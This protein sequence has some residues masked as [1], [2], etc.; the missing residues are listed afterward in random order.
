MA[1]R[2]RIELAPTGYASLQGLR[3]RKLRHEV[4]K[5]ID[6]LARRPELQGKPLV[7]PLDG[8]RSLKTGRGNFRIIYKVL[9]VEKQVQV[10]LIGERKAGQE[11]DI[12]RL[13]RRLLRNLLEED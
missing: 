2:Y 13:A 11:E 5:A 12:Y 9:P 8:L 1:S 3:D 10:L 6:A 4:A 7:G